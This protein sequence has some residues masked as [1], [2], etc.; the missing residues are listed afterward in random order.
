MGGFNVRRLPPLRATTQQNN[1]TLAVPAEIHAVPRTEVQPKL[2]NTRANTFC[3][4]Q[5]SIGNPS[6]AIDTL[7]CANSSNASN[8]LRKGDATPTVDIVDHIYHSGWVTYLL[9]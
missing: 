8:H 9:P 5:V 3:G 6:K 1:Q 4:R 7:D 2:I